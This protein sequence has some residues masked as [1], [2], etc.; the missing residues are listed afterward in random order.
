MQNY[1]SNPRCGCPRCRMAGLM[2]PAVLVTLGAL[3]L[4]DNV[5]LRGFNDTWPL[6]LIV[7]GI[8]KLLQ[9]TASTE[10]HVVPA[11]AVPVAP[12]IVTPPPVTPGGQLP[13]ANSTPDPNPDP[14]REAGNV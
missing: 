11:I 4:V 9:Y 5:G 12:V 10:G 7:I 3:F 8:I 6:L 2:G 1:K 13:P 14:N